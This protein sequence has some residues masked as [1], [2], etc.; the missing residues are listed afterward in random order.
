MKEQQDLH[1]IVYSMTK[2]S[3]RIQQSRFSTNEIENVLALTCIE[4]KDK[5]RM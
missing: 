2:I 5:D 1:Q 4:R 3:N